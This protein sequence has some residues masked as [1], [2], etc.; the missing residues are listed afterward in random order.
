M[1]EIQFTG[2]IADTT[3]AIRASGRNE[4]GGRVTF[5]IPET[6]IVQLAALMAVRGCE[7]RVTVRTA[8]DE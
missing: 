7:L 8:D 6:D 3:T 5:D 4:G 2:S 1:T